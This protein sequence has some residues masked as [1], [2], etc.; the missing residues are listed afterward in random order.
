MKLEMESILSSSFKSKSQIA[1]VVTEAWGQNNLYCGACD[2][3]SINRSPANTKVVDF[4]CGT[5]GGT[6]QLKSSSTWNERR[7]PDAG[8][9]AMM[10]AIAQDRTPNLLVLQYTPAWKVQ[11][12]LLIPR[13]FF[14][15]SA[16]EKRKPLGPNARR[17]GWV[18][19]NILLSAIAPVG[20]LR[21][22]HDGIV[23]SAAEV[24]SQY[25]RVR[26][27]SSLNVGVRGWTLDVLRVVQRLKQ[28]QFTLA[29]VYSHERE[30]AELHPKNLNVRPKIRQQLQ[31]LRNLGFIKFDGSGHY[32]VA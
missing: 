1:R 13:F 23:T 12:L 27:L 17:A 24:R 9:Y 20:K 14:N 19:C 28:L 26:P 15:E 10:A 2:A 31:L 22:V 16:I 4:E 11:N 25:Q 6:Y 30:F 18:G 32:R 29:E 21:L 8:Y 7:I 5:C 3:D